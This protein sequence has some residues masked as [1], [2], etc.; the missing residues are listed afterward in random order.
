MEREASNQKAKYLK[1]KK[2]NKAFFN[3]KTPKE[4]TV[5]L[6]DTLDSDFSSSSEADNSPDEDEKTSIAYYSESADNT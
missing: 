4:E 1:Y 6:D 2:L 5:I 3:K